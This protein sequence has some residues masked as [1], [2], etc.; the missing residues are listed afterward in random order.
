MRPRGGHFGAAPV[1]EA[2]SAPLLQCAPAKNDDL[3]AAQLLAEFARLDDYGR[4][5]A[6]A[7]V[8][9]LARLQGGAR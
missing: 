9:S 8:A 6:R 4:R 3:D 7:L 2:N 1:I 5:V